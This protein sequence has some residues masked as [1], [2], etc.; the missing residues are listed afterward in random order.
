MANVTNDKDRQESREEPSGKP[1]AKPEDYAKERDEAI[2]NSPIT[3]SEESKMLKA[4][5]FVGNLPADLRTERGELF[6]KFRKH[7][8]IL[9]Q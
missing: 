4:R 5:I 8:R 7:G 6:D 9:G 2:A 1:M 3:N